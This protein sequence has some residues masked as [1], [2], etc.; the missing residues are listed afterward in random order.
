MKMEKYGNPDEIRTSR[1]R[2]VYNKD[3]IVILSEKEKD[4]NED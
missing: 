4:N 3:R 1:F 2:N